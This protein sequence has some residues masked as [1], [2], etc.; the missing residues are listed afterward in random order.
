MGCKQRQ[1]ADRGWAGRR[2]SAA[3]RQSSI[4]PC[5]A[6]TLIELLVV[7]AVIALLI[8]I[9]LPCLQRARRQAKAIVCQ[10]HLKQWGHILAMYTSENDGYFPY[11]TFVAPIW[12][13]RGPMPL[14][15]G[16]STVGPLTQ[17]VP[18]DGIRCCPMAVRAPVHKGGLW[19]FG[20]GCGPK[21]AFCHATVSYATTRFEACRVIEPAPAFTVSYGFNAWLVVE[22]ADGFD[23]RA[24]RGANI[25]S[26]QGIPAVP[27]VLDAMLPDAFVKDRD[28]PPDG[29]EEDSGTTANNMLSFCR[30]RHDGYVNGLFL[31]WSV[32]KV[33]LKELWT[34]K[35]DKNFDTRGRW[36]RAGGARGEDWPEWMRTFKDY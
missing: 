17:P 12:L 1:R 9:L 7:I 6:F 26:I 15:A 19:G 22:S 32:R 25:L 5:R 13:F 23:R 27:V 14:E 20:L 29:K 3:V 31:D 2:S 33:G 8:A 16:D 24:P 35:W 10:A 28:R 11:G 36:T 18:T 4:I 34:L 21:G 30:N